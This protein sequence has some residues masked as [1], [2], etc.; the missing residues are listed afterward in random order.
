[1]SSTRLLNT[2]SVNERRGGTEREERISLTLYVQTPV[3]GVRTETIDRLNA[4]SVERAIK[5]FDVRTI[6]E[7]I[8]VSQGRDEEASDLPGD[9]DA[10]TKW[11]GPDVRPTFEIE[12][13]WTRTGRTVR[14][15]SL[16]EMVLAVYGAG[17]LA[18]VLPCTDGA[19]T[20]TV[21]E[22]L[23]QYESARE[24]PDGLDVDLWAA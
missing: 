3:A 24:P 9:F 2:R 1:M 20:W 23:D 14:T 8:I 13:G 10:L 19:D 12:S 18:C 15:L 4:L 6:R 16:P 21:G 7:E 5:G 11:R 17:E 22:F